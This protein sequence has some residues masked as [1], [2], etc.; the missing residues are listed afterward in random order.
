MWTGVVLPIG[1]FVLVFGMSFIVTIRGIVALRNLVLLLGG[2]QS[3]ERLI[4]EENNLTRQYGEKLETKEE[5]RGKTFFIPERHDRESRNQEKEK[6][7]GRLQQIKEDRGTFLTIPEQIVPARQSK[8]ALVPYK[9]PRI[10]THFR[11]S[12]LLLGGGVMFW[13][14]SMFSPSVIAGVVLLVWGVGLFLCFWKEKKHIRRKRHGHGYS[15][16][17]LWGIGFCLLGTGVGGYFIQNFS[18]LTTPES[19]Q[20]WLLLSCL[21]IAFMAYNLPKPPVAVQNQITGFTKIGPN[22]MLMGIAGVFISGLLTLWWLLGRV[23]FF[24]INGFLTGVLAFLIMNVI[25]VVISGWRPFLELGIIMGTLHLLFLGLAQH[26][27]WFNFWG[28]LGVGVIIFVTPFL[29]VC[30]SKHT[31]SFISDAVTLGM[32]PVF[33]FFL[34]AGNIHKVG[35]GILLEKE[36][37]FL[38]LAFFLALSIIGGVLIRTCVLNPISEEKEGEFTASSRRIMYVQKAY[39]WG[40]PLLLVLEGVVLVALSDIKVVWM[41][42]LGLFILSIGYRLLRGGWW[43]VWGNV[44]GLL[45]GIFAIDSTAL[46]IISADELSPLK[47]MFIPNWFINGDDSVLLIPILLLLFILTLV[48]IEYGN[49]VVRGKKRIHQLMHKRKHR[50]LTDEEEKE[51][52]QLKDHAYFPNSLLGA[53]LIVGNIYWFANIWFSAHQIFVSPTLAT[54]LSLGLFSIVGIFIYKVGVDNK[55]H[56]LRVYGITILLFIGLR[57]GSV[58]WWTL[59]G[60]VIVPIFIGVVSLVWHLGVSCKDFNLHYDKEECFRG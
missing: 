10:F 53:L 30:F 59:E 24:T 40:V 44:L 19:I 25:I 26:V 45:A 12:L 34:V 1:V 13:L 29:Y 5:E 23:E 7:R 11:L 49:F 56:S 33:L 20:V 22:P 4:A 60:W 52:K 41:V 43:P 37:P 54:S 55:L 32:L 31:K 28:Y 2:D 46:I 3:K 57:I 51:K 8:G 47:N 48:I 36:A 50:M 38:I 35:E 17:Q 6:K 42:F 27:S 58:I 9:K 14:L 21:S 18:F 15:K 16:A 39:T